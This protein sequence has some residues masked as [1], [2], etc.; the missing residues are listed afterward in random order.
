MIFIKPGLFGPATN[1]PD[2]VKFA[3]ASHRHIATDLAE[4]DVGPVLM[5]KSFEI[6]IIF[7]KY[8]H[9]DLHFPDLTE[10]VVPR[11]QRVQTTTIPQSMSP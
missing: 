7:C 11:S 8:S 6:Y 3:P 2:P 10:K 5:S 4:T 9:V 1:P